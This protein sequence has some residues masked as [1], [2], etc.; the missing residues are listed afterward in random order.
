MKQ[1]K[2]Y[3][4]PQPQRE[5]KIIDEYFA[6]IF[7]LLLFWQIVLIVRMRRQDWS[8]RMDCIPCEWQNNALD[9]HLDAQLHNNGLDFQM[10]SYPMCSTFYSACETLIGQLGQ[11]R[12]QLRDGT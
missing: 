6:F 8:R 10:C 1:I 3:V 9:F 11:G 7:L 12:Q 2:N 4:N 5:L